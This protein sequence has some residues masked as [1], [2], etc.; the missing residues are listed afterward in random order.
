[1]TVLLMAMSSYVSADYSMNIQLS[2]DR[3]VQGGDVTATCDVSSQQPMSS[4]MTVIWVKRTVENEEVEIGSE[5][6]M[7]DR[8]QRTRRYSARRQQQADPKHLR[9]TLTIVGRDFLFLKMFRN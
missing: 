8:F 2:S 5:T 4:T 6:N 3:V 1:M 9:F 7:T